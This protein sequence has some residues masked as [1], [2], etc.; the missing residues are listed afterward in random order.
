MKFSETVCAVFVG[1]MLAYLLAMLM[2]GNG[3]CLCKGASSMLGMSDPFDEFYPSVDGFVPV[4]QDP[5]SPVDFAYPKS[6]R[7]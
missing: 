7:D 3:R 5:S 1:V 4:L 2:T 6:A